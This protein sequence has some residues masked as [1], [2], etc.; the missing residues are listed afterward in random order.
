[1]KIE[2]DDL[3]K[4]YQRYISSKIPDNRN[5]CLSPMALYDSFE[6]S[7]SLR[8]KKNIIDHITECAFCREEFKILLELQRNQAS[9]IK[10]ISENPSTDSS[11]DKL[12]TAKIG[13][14]SIWK[15]AYILYGLVLILTAYYLILQRTSFSETQ[16][17][18]EHKILLLTPAR[19][20]IFP[21]PLTFQWQGPPTSQYYLLELFDNSLLSIWTSDKL[22]DIQTQL[23][24][25]ILSRL[26]SGDYYF[27]MI[28]AFSGTQK[29][30]QSELSRFLVLIK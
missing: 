5:K 26:H 7:M 16:R 10:G 1:M 27:W 8:C 12:D 24:D 21:K 11:I 19:M 3:K 25:E 9:S 28:S 30:S 13:K 18:S 17:A 29:I 20:H 23:P 4:L 22:F 15:Y 2:Y 14:P 6:S